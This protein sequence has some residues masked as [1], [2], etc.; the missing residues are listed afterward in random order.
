M[1]KASIENRGDTKSYVTTRHS[2]FVLDTGGDGANPIDT[3]LASLCGCL[4]HYVRDYLV[5]L[6][7]GQSGFSIDAEAAIAPGTAS[8]AEIRVRIDL[9]ELKLDSW[10]RADLLKFVENCKIHKIVKDNPGVSVTIAV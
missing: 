4:G 1:Y 8:L 9:G 6:H 2:S 3:F 5:D 7:L 10:Q